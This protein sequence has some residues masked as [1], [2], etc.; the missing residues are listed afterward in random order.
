MNRTL[1]QARWVVGAVVLAVVPL[2]IGI[3]EAVLPEGAR[4]GLVRDSVQNQRANLESVRTFRPHANADSKT[5]WESW[6]R[7]SLASQSLE[8]GSLKATTI[9]DGISYQLSLQGEFPALVR[10]VRMAE[11]AEFPCF[12]EHFAVSSRDVRGGPVNADLVW[13]CSQKP[14]SP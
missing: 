8:L 5:G 11:S 4:F 6:I 7:T 10:W 1:R 13:S 2:L 3:R 14:D 12:I 9:R